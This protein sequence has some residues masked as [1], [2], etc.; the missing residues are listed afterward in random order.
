MSNDQLKQE[1]TATVGGY[2]KFAET[3][4]GQKGPYRRCRVVF[5]KDENAEWV[6]IR[7][8]LE[9][10]EQENIPDPEK[11]DFIKV[12]GLLTVFGEPGEAYIFAQK[13]ENFVEAKDIP[14]NRPA[15]KEPQAKSGGYTRRGSNTAPAQSRTAAGNGRRGY[16]R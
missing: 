7:L 6:T 15:D 3:K 12:T 8:P 10:L 11:G 14:D 13:V 4:E 2:V 1:K 5:G 16:R 9:L